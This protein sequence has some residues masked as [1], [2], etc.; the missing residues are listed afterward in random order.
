MNTDPVIC[1]QRGTSS[2]KFEVR[3]PKINYKE[4]LNLF[5]NVKYIRIKNTIYIKIIKKKHHTK[6][7]KQPTS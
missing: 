4:K 2:N 5:K 3:K 1:K 7:K 6:E